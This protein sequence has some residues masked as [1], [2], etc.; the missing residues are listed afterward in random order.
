MWSS[1]V[2]SGDGKFTFSDASNIE[3]TW[4]V[5]ERASELARSTGKILNIIYKNGDMFKGTSDKIVG[6]GLITYKDGTFDR[7]NWTLL[8]PD[9]SYLGEV[10]P[11]DIPHGN[12]T[13]IYTSGA[14]YQ[15]QWNNGTISGDGTYYHNSGEIKGTWTPIEEGVW[16]GVLVEEKASGMGTLIAKNGSRWTGTMAAG[17]K[18][19]GELWDVTGKKQPG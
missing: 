4:E 10:N 12:G 13:V 3:D 14:R 6:E 1:G 5:T 11:E 8:T 16:S 15:G 18:E 17:E 2:I 7:G 9:Q 19:A